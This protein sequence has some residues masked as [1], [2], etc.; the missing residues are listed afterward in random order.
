MISIMH[1]SRNLVYRRPFGAR[2]AGDRVRLSLDVRGG[3]PSDVLLRVW[4]G[5]EQIFKMT[6]E[7]GSSV[8]QA[9]FDLPAEPGLVWYYFIVTLPGRRLFYGNNPEKIG[10]RGKIYSSEPPAYQITVYQ[11]QDTPKWMEGGLIYHIFPDRFFNPYRQPLSVKP[12]S[13]Y[14]DDWYRTP[15]Y[16]RDRQ[17]GEIMAYDFYGGNLDGI[18]AKLDYLA[19]FGVKVIYLNPIFQSVSNHR[20]DTG[21]YEKVDPVLGD[22]AAFNRLCREAGKRGMRVILDGV[23]SHTG[24][25]SRYFNK[26]GCYKELGAFQSK[27]SPYYSWYRFS[28]YPEEYESWWGIGNLPNVDELN[29][30]YLDYIIE[31]RRSVTARWLEAGATGWRL[32]VADELPLEF[33]WRLRRRMKEID[34]DSF[35]L[36]EV[37]EDASHKISYGELRNYFAGGLL[38]S[39][40]NYPFRQSVLDFLLGQETSRKVM[41][42]LYSLYENYPPDNFAIL[43][44]L[45]GTHDTVR[46]LTA[47]SGSVPDGLSDSKKRKFRLRAEQKELAF[48]RLKQ[49][50]L[51]QMTFAG[52]PSVY[53]GD[54]AG[55]EGFADPYNRAAYPWGREN[56][57]VYKYYWKFSRLRRRYPWLLGGQ[58]RPLLSDPDIV[59]YMRWQEDDFSIIA[60]NR[61]DNEKFFTASCDFTVVDV[62]SGDGYQPQEGRLAVKIPGG[63][64]R[65]LQKTVIFPDRRRRAG[66]LLHPSS[67]PSNYGIGDIGPISL[68]FID[69]L[70]ESGHTVWQVLPLGPV[71][72]EGS[73]YAGNSAFAG[74]V[75]LLSPDALCEDGLLTCQELAHACAG[76]AEASG[77]DFRRAAARKDRLCKMAYERFK[78]KRPADYADFYR[79][80]KYWLADYCLYASL[81]DYFDG[82]P[83]QRWPQGIA[84]RNPEEIVKWQE[85]LAEDIAYHA[86]LQYVFDRQWRKVCEKA[87][88]KGITII[89]DMPFYLAADSADAWAHRG[90]FDLDS[91]GYAAGMAGV[92]PDYFS[93]SGQLWGNPVYNW[94]A[95]QAEQYKWWLRRL[96]RN[97]QM[98]DILRIDHFRAIDSYWR[99]PKG[100]ET[101][102]HGNWQKGPGDAFLLAVQKEFSGLPFIVEDLGDV[103][104]SVGKLRDRFSLPGMNILQF[105]LPR[106]QDKILYSG[107]HDNDTLLGWCEKERGSQHFTALSAAAGAPAILEAEKMVEYIL[108]YAYANDAVWLMTPMQDILGLGSGARMNT[109]GTVSCNWCWRLPPG[110][111]NSDIRAKMYELVKLGGRLPL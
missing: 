48:R 106:D 111:L 21:D 46:L 18:T 26:E 104:P 57:A 6:A 32:D 80:N 67:L 24:S 103:T 31:N 85:I 8:Y 62:L 84:A 93:D 88:E 49:A 110:A 22:M 77:V 58:W 78:E 38:D 29:P 69:F 74:N 66:I 16:A 15:L 56:G 79:E 52:L 109:P 20:F 43:M 68:A 5:R 107:T 90:L 59:A 51:W 13:I 55:L 97:L 108:R 89:G 86:F 41:A 40:M 3:R 45:L 9:E 98:C 102:M 73:P 101:A 94:P 105:G 37:W 14:H 71:D 25:D 61:A 11:P 63:G 92:P 75:L 10:G 35:L 87:K 30:D 72:E 91:K 100:S 39:V 12:D 2:P 44:N 23:F 47:L 54:E 36:G 4:S 99:V 28:E 34:K 19:D 50:V 82:K 70:A 81:K 95:C 83:W 60:I 53:Y 64:A 42:D 76:A 96:R 17:T 7:E 1:D 27:D 65:I 33:I